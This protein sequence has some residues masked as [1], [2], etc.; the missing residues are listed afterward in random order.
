[1]NS[2]GLFKKALNEI[3]MQTGSDDKSVFEQKEWNDVKWMTLG[4]MVTLEVLADAMSEENKA[5]VRLML[6]KPTLVMRAQPKAIERVEKKKLQEGD[7]VNFFR[8]TNDICG[9]SRVLCSA[10]NIADEIDA[11]QEAVHAFDSNAVFYVRGSS[12]EKPHGVHRNANGEVVDL[13]EYA[14]AYSTKI[15]YVVEIQFGE[16]L[17]FLCF[18]INSMRHVD[19]SV[20]STTK[21]PSLFKAFQGFLLKKPDAQSADELRALICTKYAKHEAVR[22][23]LLA[24]FDAANQ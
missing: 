2:I 4:E 5:N 23:K 17:A 9:A 15:G 19:P 6:N 10:A 24:C 21:N 8:V 20:P 7:F 1:M 18:E 16:P 3:V 22:E 12:K 13:I 14:Y 11:M